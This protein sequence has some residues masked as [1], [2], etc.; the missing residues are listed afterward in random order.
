MKL[1]EITELNRK[2]AVAFLTRQ[3][4]SDVM[5]SGGRAIRLSALDGY[6]TV[7]NGKITGAVT[8]LAENGAC[9]VVSLDSVNENRGT[10]TALLSAAVQA[11]KEKGCRAVYLYTTNDNTRA[12]RFYQKRGFDMTGFCR[13]AVDRARKIKPEIPPTGED[14]IPIRHEIRF[15]LFF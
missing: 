10:G 3:W 4:G 11:A 6:V 5:V 1:Y 15:E 9:E 2:E 8:Y 7:E 13:G 12:M 14:G